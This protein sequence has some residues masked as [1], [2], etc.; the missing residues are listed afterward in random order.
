MTNVIGVI[1]A[2]GAGKRLYPLTANQAKPAVSFAGQYRIIDFVLSN[3]YNSGF[4]HL[5]A[6]TQFKP[7]NLHQHLT[8]YWQPYLAD[9]GFIKICQTPHAQNTGTAGA[10]KQNLETILA[11]NPQAVIIVS[12]D[13]IYKM[14]Y[15]QMLAFHQQKKACLTIAAIAVP[16]H[17][18]HHFGIIETDDDNRMTA[19]IEKPQHP[20]KHIP[21]RPGYVL[22]SMGN[23]LFSADG[24]RQALEDIPQ[25]ACC[26]F[27][28]D[29]IPALYPHQP[30]YAYDFSTNQ[31]PVRYGISGYW[32]DVGTLDSYYQCQMDLL[33]HPGVLSLHNHKWPIHC[34]GQHRE[35]SNRIAAS[36]KIQRSILGR[37]CHIG[38][39]SY[40]EGVI[41]GD[42]IQIEEDCS[43]SDAI[44][45]SDTHIAAGTQINPDRIS[46]IPGAVRS[47]Q[48][49]IVI[50]QGSRIG[51]AAA[52]GK[53]PATTWSRSFLLR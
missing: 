19:F 46:S 42:N 52:P 14:D 17:Q 5:F 3:L 9:E 7:E 48:G 4:T 26:D 50:P 47:E 38:E 27:G 51:F 41:L 11:A 16:E 22:A 30:V 23:Y 33:Q 44:I 35:D 53:I 6:L 10:V 29:I 25:T 36:A 1:L 15:R 32:R 39:H 28:H 21:G 8:A 20:V 45:D 2:G 40:L 49:I 13:H 12:A 24:L 31:L 18:A 34:A 43:I 37:H